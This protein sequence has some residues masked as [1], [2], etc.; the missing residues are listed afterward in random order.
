MGNK[1]QKF[2]RNSKYNSQISSP[3]IRLQQNKINGL[4]LLP[5]ELIY[6]LFEYLLPIDIIRAFQYDIEKFAPL[7]KEHI[8]THGFNL[9][10]VP[11]NATHLLSICLSLI[12]QQHL[13]IC[14][15]ESFLSNVLKS[16]PSPKI[17]TIMI[18]RSF[19]ESFLA[20]LLPQSINCDKLIIEY[21]SSYSR[22]MKDVDIIPLLSS[23]VKTLILRNVIFSINESIIDYKNDSLQHI[24]CILKNEKE[25]RELL[26]RFSMLISIDI[27]LVYY[28]IS[29][30]ST[31]LS[32][33]KHFRIAY[34]D[35]TIIDLEKF[36][37][38]TKTYDQTV[39]SL[40][41]FATNSSIVLR[42]CNPINYQNSFPY[43]LTYIRRLTIEC[44][45][46]PW[47]HEFVTFLRQMFPNTRT[48]YAM[49]NVDTARF[50]MTTI[51]AN[52]SKKGKCTISEPY[53]KFR[54]SREVYGE[55]I[56][57]IAID[58]AYN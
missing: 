18:N 25:L 23:S 19:E 43:P 29:Q 41:W 45:L 51:T 32:L 49:Q 35:E 52:D 7:I 54:N 15:N 42:S 46:E 26:I 31:I 48:L 36:P 57:Y 44:T 27:R 50:T 34:P 55:P 24:R 3:L 8:V 30:F 58:H 21:K 11:S 56:R 2:V 17:L 9:L 14:T 5:N 22:Q 12:E 16:I 47:S 39:Y 40:P 20:K 13:S 6:C 33:P 53:Y 38:G 4:G 10:K 37:H 28:H 1:Q